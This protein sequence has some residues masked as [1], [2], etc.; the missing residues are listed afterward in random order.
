MIN[1]Q[2]NQLIMSL[3]SG[4]ALMKVLQ[5]SRRWRKMMEK[6]KSSLKY[7]TWPAK[8]WPGELTWCTFYLFFAAWI[9]SEKLAIVCGVLEYLEKCLFPGKESFAN[10]SKVHSANHKQVLQ[11]KNLKSHQHTTHDSLEYKVLEL[12]STVSAIIVLHY[13]Y[14]LIKSR[15]Y[16]N[17]LLPTRRAT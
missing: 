2:I 1:H 16:E 10:N 12:L 5:S 17:K 14:F 7:L 4:A 9:Y 13:Y 11:N 3:L 6:E 8:M 15:K